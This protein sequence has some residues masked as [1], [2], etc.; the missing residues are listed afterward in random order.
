[1]LA[2]VNNTILNMVVQAP[3]G[4]SDSAS[5]SS[6]ILDHTKGEGDDRG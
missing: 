2:T 4:D 3:L 6:G 1:M 5:S